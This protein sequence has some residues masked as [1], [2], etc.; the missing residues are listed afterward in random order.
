MSSGLLG[1]FCPC[2]RITWFLW[3]GELGES[4]PFLAEILGFVCFSVLRF[5]YCLQWIRENYR[6]IFY[7]L[8]SDL[9]IWD[10]GLSSLSVFAFALRILVAIQGPFGGKTG[11][12]GLGIRIETCVLL[13]SLYLSD[14]HRQPWQHSPLSVS[15][16]LWLLGAACW[17]AA[18]LFVFLCRRLG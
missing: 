18:L 10:V 12:P 1:Y 4:N 16:L 9:R 5:P 8:S 7:M 13:R 15:S 11:S 3:G 2:F 6:A 17:P 14:A